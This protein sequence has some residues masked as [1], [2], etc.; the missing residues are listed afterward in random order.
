M[1]ELT[2]F[3]TD[4]EQLKTQRSHVQIKMEESVKRAKELKETLSKMGYNN[5][6]EAKDAYSHL[7]ADAEHKHAEVKGYINQIKHT[8]ATIPSKDEIL[9][10]LKDEVQ[11]LPAQEPIPVPTEALKAS[12]LGLSKEDVEALATT[13]VEDAQ[14]AL[15]QEAVKETDAEIKADLGIDGDLMDNLD[16][17]GDSQ[18]AETPAAEQKPKKD[19]NSSSDGGSSNIMDLDIYL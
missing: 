13:P 9:Q 12:D 7:L 5:L 2:Q 14:S 8:E 1:E 3:K 16:M 19:T 15:L 18:P 11:V 4:L 10:K 17:F 6:Q